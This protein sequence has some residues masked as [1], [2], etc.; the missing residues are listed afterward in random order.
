MAL[1]V[2]MVLRVLIL[3][4]T[5]EASGLA[6]RLEG[7]AR[8]ATTLSFAGR[9]RSPVLPSIPSRV[10][11]FG[12]A[13]GLAAW[14]RDERVA[15]LV[16][17]THPFAARISANAVTAAAAAG[18]DLLG[19]SRPAWQARP[20]DDW[21]EFADLAGARDALGEMPRRVFLA[22]GR[23]ELAGFAGTP[24]DYVVRSVDPPAPGAAPG[25]AVFIAARGPFA[26]DDEI[27]LLR[28]HRIEL[29][30][31][32]NS[33]GSAAAAKLAACR[34]LRIPVLMVAR[35]AIPPRDEVADDAAAFDWL[36]A[37][38]DAALRGV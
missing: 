13:E 1:R 4:G 6:R 8:F 5:S 21:T 27:A 12:G 25:G 33:G 30:V 7:D 20:G 28:A 16:D 34:E 26:L 23:N 29:L 19:I 17:A 22:I 31:C 9:T 11:G 14:L 32:K 37:R 10:G 38:H 18:V 3:G 36:L 15:A 2:L 24:H 35:P